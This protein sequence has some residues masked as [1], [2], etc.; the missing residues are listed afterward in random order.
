MKKKVMRFLESIKLYNQEELQE[1]EED[2]EN[3]AGP[4]IAM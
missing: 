3:D 4:H 1:S 2:I